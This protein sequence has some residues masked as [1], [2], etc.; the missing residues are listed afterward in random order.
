MESQTSEA[1]VSTA[2]EG[3]TARQESACCQD[4]QK[5]Q[6]SQLD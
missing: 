2:V 5:H 6:Q 3:E 4:G 1:L